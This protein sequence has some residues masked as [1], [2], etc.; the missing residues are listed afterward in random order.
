MS[1]NKPLEIGSEETKFSEDRRNIFIWKN[2]KV[3]SYQPQDW[4]FEKLAGT[5]NTDRIKNKDTDEFLYAGVDDLK[6]D[7]E[8]RRVFSWMGINSTP[9]NDPGNWGKQAEW[10]V[11]KAENGFLIKNLEFSDYLYAAGDPHAYDENRRS[12]F[13]W[14][15]LDTLGRE[16]VWNF[17]KSLL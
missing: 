7:P 9:L 3:D 5:S 4:I 2:P 1:Y 14:K 10:E 6:R 12:V 11:I 17:D 8:R 15:N 16:G 13:A